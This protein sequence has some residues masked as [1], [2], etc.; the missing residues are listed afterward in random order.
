MEYRMSLTPRL[1]ALGACCV[2]AL[3]VLVFLLGM[4]IG[5]YLR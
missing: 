3:L 1:L 4:Q 2:L 5:H